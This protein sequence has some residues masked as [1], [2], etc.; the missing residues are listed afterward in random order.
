[1]TFEAKSTHIESQGQARKPRRVGVCVTIQPCQLQLFTIRSS[2]NMTPVH[3]TPKHLHATWLLWMHYAATIYGPA[4]SK[5]RQ[6]KRRAA[7]CSHVT[8]PK[9]ISMS[10][11]S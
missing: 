11:M 7:T 9:C 3:N 8:L 6:R 5:S 1:M 4:Y 10:N 2:R